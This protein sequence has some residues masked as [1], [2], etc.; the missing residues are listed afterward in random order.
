MF[1]ERFGLPV[2]MLSSIAAAAWSSC[3][4]CRALRAVG[5]VC[6]WVCGGEGCVCVCVCVWGVWGG[7]GVRKRRKEE[8]HHEIAT[9]YL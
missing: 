4:C 8:V 9:N 1:R 5:A 6:V 2:L 7:G 3:C